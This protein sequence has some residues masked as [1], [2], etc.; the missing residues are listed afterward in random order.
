MTK[1][2]N[3]KGYRLVGANDLGFNF[4]FIRNGIA[5]A[6][7]P[8]VEVKSVLHHPSLTQMNK[9]WDEIKDWKFQEG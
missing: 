8:E 4:I 1:L 2:A 5:D 9:K 7:I 3:Q 6:F